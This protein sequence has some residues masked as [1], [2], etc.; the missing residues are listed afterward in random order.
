MSAIFF[1]E[2]LSLVCVIAIGCVAAQAEE[3][4]NKVCSPT[5]HVFKYQREF[6]RST[7]KT[8]TSSTMITLRCLLSEECYAHSLSS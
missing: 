6:V 8:K 3:V 5:D 7:T 1:S 2:L 4:E